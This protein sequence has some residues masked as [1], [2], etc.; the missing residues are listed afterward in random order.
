MWASPPATG[1][2]ANVTRPGDYASHRQTETEDRG[3]NMASIDD[4]S[5]PSNSLKA[6][7]LEGSEI[8]LTITGYEAKEFTEKGKNGQEYQALKPVFSFEETEKTFV[9]NKTNREAVAYA[10]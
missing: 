4:F 2:N 8:E 6:A 10:Y 1:F 9:M 5:T 7:D 3:L